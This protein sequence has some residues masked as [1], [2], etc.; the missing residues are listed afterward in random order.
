LVILVEMY[1]DNDAGRVLKRIFVDADSYL[2][3]E[4]YDYRDGQLWSK[5]VFTNL[6]I[7]PELKDS[8]F[9]IK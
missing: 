6:V 1:K 8:L 4:W 9:D 2:P 5:S 3:V 7:N